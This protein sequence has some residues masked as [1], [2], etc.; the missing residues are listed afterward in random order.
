VTLTGTL[1]KRF[2]GGDVWVL[3]PDQGAPVQLK[4]RVPAELVDRRVEVRGEPVDSDLSLA[5]AG[6]IWE[7][8]SIKAR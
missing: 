6:E 5:M 8:R 7:V 2:F 1:R 4:G 3:E